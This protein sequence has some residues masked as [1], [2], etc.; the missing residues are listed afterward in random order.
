M[1]NVARYYYATFFYFI[2]KKNM[3]FI[4]DSIRELKHV[5][6]PTKEDSRRYFIAVLSVL[7]LFGIYLFIFSTIF[8]KT[9]IYLKDFVNPSNTKVNVIA[10]ENLTWTIA[11]WTLELNNSTNT[12]ATWA[13][14]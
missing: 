9:L 8:S 2:Y 14:E 1:T 10:P 13:T 7:I 6:W 5:V 4:K 3:N 12:V 11:T